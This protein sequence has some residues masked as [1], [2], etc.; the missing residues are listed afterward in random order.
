MSSVRTQFDFV[1]IVCDTYLSNNIKSGER[2]LRG[3]GKK[4]VLKSTSMRLPSDML[5]FLRNGQKKEM[6]F[7]LLADAVIEEKQNHL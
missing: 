2:R 4:Y 7:N 3:E 6:L 1:F 5:N